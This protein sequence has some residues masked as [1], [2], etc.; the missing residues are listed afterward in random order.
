[1]ERKYLVALCFILKMSF[2]LI[3]FFWSF[4]YNRLG[5]FKIRGKFS[6]NRY[7]VWIR[8]LDSSILTNDPKIFFSFDFKNGKIDQIWSSWYINQDYVLFPVRL[9]KFKKS[10]WYTRTWM[11]CVHVNIENGLRHSVFRIR[12]VRTPPA[13]RFFLPFRMR[14]GVL[15]KRV[16]R[17]VPKTTDGQCYNAF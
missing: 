7:T 4:D 10:K 3:Q 5:R 11:C 1:M 15:V 16:P 6:V 17:R 8:D 13:I 9:G 12:T 2:N 14:A